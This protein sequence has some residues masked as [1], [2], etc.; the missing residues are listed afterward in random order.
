MCAQIFL[1]FSSCCIR[2]PRNSE[3]LLHRAAFESMRTIP[4]VLLMTLLPANARHLPS[5]RNPEFEEISR[6]NDCIQARFLSRTSFGMNR[7]AVQLHGIRKFQPENSNEQAVVDGIR[8]KGYELAVFLAGR[9][10]LSMDLPIG[11]QG[12]AFVT[13]LRDPKQLPSSV[14]LLSDSR[15]ALASFQTG[16][17]YDIRMGDWTVAMRPLRASN[18]GC[19]GCHNPGASPSGVQIG[20]ALGVVMYVFRPLKAE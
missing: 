1:D 5:T 15:A 6:L 7:I 3:R 9:S 4:F 20:D 13:N 17:V 10:L 19:V 2:T 11:V 14:M 16:D 8:K 18:G 12:P